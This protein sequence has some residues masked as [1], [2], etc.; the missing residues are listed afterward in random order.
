[1]YHLNNAGPGA[2]AWIRSLK[3]ISPVGCVLLVVDLQ[4]RLLPAI[5]KGAEVL[6]TTGRLLAAASLLNVPSVFTEQNVGGLGSTAD[7]IR[8]PPQEVFHKMTFDACRTDGFLNRLKG[9]SDIVVVGCEAHVC[10]QQTVL[11]LI[12]AGRRVFVVGDAVGSRTRQNK[13]AALQRMAANG[14]EIVT[15]EMVIF[16]WLQTSEHPKFRDVLALVK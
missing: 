16:E 5:D 11:G 14:V 7:E 2:E 3:T 1:M 4:T 12:G 8:P 13:D 6:A 9:F 15:S 10:V